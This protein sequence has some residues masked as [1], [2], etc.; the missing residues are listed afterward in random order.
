MVR[1]AAP[2][3]RSPTQHILSLPANVCIKELLSMKALP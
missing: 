3:C 1:A 2:A